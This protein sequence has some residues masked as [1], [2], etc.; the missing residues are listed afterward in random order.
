M[1]P[2]YKATF[3]RHR[4]LF[5]LPVALAMVISLLFVLGSPKAYEAQATLWIDNPPPGASSIDNANP[6]TL[7]PSTRAQQLLT[8]LLAS[9]SFRLAVGARGGLT[10]YLAGHTSTGFSPVALIRGKQPLSN[11]VESALDPKHVLTATPG[12]QFLAISLKGPNPAVAANT[13]WALINQLNHARAK[14]YIDREEGAVTFFQTQVDAATEAIAAAQTPQTKDAALTR[15]ARMTKA[16]NQARLNLDAVKL[17]KGAFKVQDAPTPPTG[18]VSG[19]KKAVF[20]VAA[21]LFVGA[22]VS[23]IGILL[24]SGREERIARAAE[25]DTPGLHVLEHLEPMESPESEWWPMGYENGANG[26]N[27]S[28]DGAH[29]IGKPTSQ[30]DRGD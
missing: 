11:R 29:E 22:I 15:L 1:N 7:T 28:H 2:A 21:G 16:L 13:L 10:R 5:S 17:Q 30:I 26:T 27:G 9:R 25:P 23:F 4:I 12:P 18:P 19:K 6:A 24:L 14:I 20:A 8:E 3:L